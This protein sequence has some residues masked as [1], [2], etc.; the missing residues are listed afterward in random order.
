MSLYENGCPVCLCGDASLKHI[1]S[2]T[3]PVGKLVDVSH[4]DSGYLVDCPACGQFIVTYQDNVNL[5]S[6]RLRSDWQAYQ[7][8][9]L[10]REQ[11]VRG[12]PP[13]WL[14]DGMDPYGPLQFQNIVPID[15]GELLAR[16]PRTVAERINRT[17]CNI[18]WLSPIAG[19]PVDVI[20]LEKS[21][22]FSKTME[23]FSYNIKALVDEGLLKFVRKEAHAVAVV[24]LTPHGWARFDALTTRAGAP[25]NPA[26]VAM[27]FGGSKEKALMD[28]IFQEAIQPA[29]EDSGYRTTRVDLAEHNDWIM[30]KVLGDIRR[31]PF[32]VADFTGHRNGV[33]FEAGFARGLGT[34]V[35]NTCRESD[36]D[37]AHF[38]TKQ[39]NHIR[40]KTS[41]DLRKSL[42]YRII[43][44]IGDGPQPRP[45]RE[46]SAMAS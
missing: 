6:A 10:L 44:T 15:R 11:T 40:W 22:G 12:L 20:Q 29:I 1:D 21:V 18:A 30:D 32:V 4:C 39:L 41:D 34:P 45:T 5:R 23:E 24:S 46:R 28:E 42:Y 8:S 16:W 38:D 31:A 26:F 9:S 17:L 2:A 33:Y 13:F 3:V 37:Q 36:F 19:H 27:W 25:E 43:A 7:L 35:I 14:R